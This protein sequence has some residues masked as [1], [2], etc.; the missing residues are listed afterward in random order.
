MPVDGRLVLFALTGL[1]NQVFE[2]LV[3]DGLA[4]DLLV[5]RAERGPYP[6]EPLPFIGE[7]AS[8]LGVPHRLDAAGEAMSLRKARP[9]LLTAT[10][11][12]KIGNPCWRRAARRSTCTR[13][14]CRAIADR[15]LSSGRSIMGMP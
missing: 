7:V 14:S 3:A 2:R 8:R 9:L 12:R 5:T 13:R 1:G 6:Y 15:T 4:P 10:Y 11:H